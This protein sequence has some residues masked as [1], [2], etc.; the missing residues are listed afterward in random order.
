MGR[1]DSRLRMESESVQIVTASRSSWSLFSSAIS[2]DCNTAVDL[3]PEA[4]PAIAK[5]LGPIDDQWN[6]SR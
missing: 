1:T 4:V 5:V 6:D 3:C 2:L